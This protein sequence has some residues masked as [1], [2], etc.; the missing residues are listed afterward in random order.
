MPKTVALEWKVLIYPKTPVDNFYTPVIWI[1][2]TSNGK[3]LL[4]KLSQIY[5][6]PI[7]LV[8]NMQRVSEAIKSD[9]RQSFDVLP[10]SD[11]Y[12]LK[13]AEGGL[14]A[15]VCESVSRG[16]K[17]LKDC[18]SV[19][20]KATVDVRTVK[21][22]LV[23]AKRPGEATSKASITVYGSRDEGL[24]V[25]N[26]LSSNKIFLQ[27]PEEDSETVA[28]FNPQEAQFPGIEEPAPTV[29]DCPRISLTSRKG[30]KSEFESE[31]LSQAISTIYGSL[32]RFRIQDQQKGG[33][34]VLTNLLQ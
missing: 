11:Y 14:F 7:K 3:D 28:Y 6:V 24:A 2:Y 29:Q 10:H 22:V 31:S 9:A 15:Q 20:M 32:K 19:E 18:H 33:A 23:R 17:A 8:G 30:H 25:G 34:R 26:A 13:F 16:F 1:H 5:H 4:N 21:D 27:D 12:M